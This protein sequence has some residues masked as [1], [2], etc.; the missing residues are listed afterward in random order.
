M[1][2]TK[3]TTEYAKDVFSVLSSSFTNP[4]SQDTI[5]SL[6]ESN[7]AE[8]FGAFEEDK[9][10]GYA[11]LEW[12]LDE[13]SL[14]DIAVLPSER[15]KGIANLLMQALITEALERDLQFITLEVREGNTPA[16]NLYKKFGF[17]PMGKRPK[18]YKDPVEDAL[19]M[20]KNLK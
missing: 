18:Y 5:K 20:T 3:L 8:C 11:A 13:G 1:T 7:S 10:V 9:L 19:L 14:T 2:I 12:V 16:I 17:E 6:L 15:K 4:W